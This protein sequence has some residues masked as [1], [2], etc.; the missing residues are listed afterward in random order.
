[1][2]LERR[3]R[4]SSFA[5]L[6]L[7]YW[8]A[9]IAKRTRLFGLVLADS[10]GFLVASN[11]RG[12]EAEELAAIA[13]LLGRPS[14]QA[15]VPVSVVSVRVEEVCLYLCAIGDESPRNAALRLAEG[16]VQRILTVH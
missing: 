12:P 11:L 2:T 16:G 13:P 1:M 10:A 3:R 6:A 8:F 9:A 14:Q 7:R 5:G 15:E 4:R